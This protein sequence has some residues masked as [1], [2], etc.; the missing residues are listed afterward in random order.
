MIRLEKVN[1]YFNRFKKNQIHVINDTSLDF[2]EKGLVALLGPSGC[3][4]TTLR[5]AIGGRDKINN[6]NIYIN[7]KK[8]PKI[9]H[10]KDKVRTIN[11]GYI[12]QN[13]NL[14]DNLSV[15]DNVA[16]SLKMI[17]IKNKK[18]IDERV[19][20]VLEKV[21]M[22]RFKYRPCNM[23]SGGQRQ[24]V[25]I[26]RAIV[27]NPLLII[28]DEPTGNL[29]SKNTIEIMNIIKSISQS[30]LVILVTHEKD[31]A[32]FY[33][34]RVINIEDGK[35]ISDKENKSDKLD[36]RFD[37]NMYLKDFKYN[38]KIKDNNFNINIYSDTKEKLKLDIVLKNGNIYIKA[39]DDKIEVVDDDSPI[40][41]INDH[42]KAIDKKDYEKSNF[43]LNKLDNSKYR[44]RYASIFNVFSNISNAIKKILGY[45]F[46]KKVLLLGFLASS[47]FILFAISN[48][49]GVTDIQDTSFMTSNRDYIY[50]EA[51]KGNLD[52][53]DKLKKVEG[54]SYILP[55]NSVKSF[56]YVDNSLYQFNTGKV[57]FSASVTSINNI[58]DVIYGKMPSEK[59]EVVVDTMVYEISKKNDNGITF[60]NFNILSA[61]DLVGKKISDGTHSYTISGISN[62][63]SPSIYVDESQ[64]NNILENVGNNKS[65]YKDY[66]NS[67]VTLKEGRWPTGDYETIIN[68][69]NKATTKLNS[70]IDTKINDH[71]LKVVGYYTTPYNNNT[72]Y[73]NSNMIT[74]SNIYNYKGF[75]VYSPN[76]EKTLNY[77]NDNGYKARDTY[78]YDRKKYVDSIKSSIR[79]TCIISGILLGISFIEI[80]LMIRASFMSRIKEVGIMRAIGVKKLDIYKMFMG[81][82]IIIAT[83]TGIPGVIIMGSIIDAISEVPYITNMFMINAKV[84]II[85]LILIYGFN[86]VVGLLPVW[87]TIRKTPASIL[88]RNDV[89]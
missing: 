86:L 8:M 57:E 45:S 30:K 11:I 85:S 42:Y 53:Y 12:F 32:Y 83:I 82:I 88:S 18:D 10:F 50:V 38:E 35:V 52:T 64:F 16:I 2:P 77:L 24:R 66:S 70:E 46:I 62:T 13:Y 15:Y 29:D 87:N 3:G 4:K 59:N 63:G 37:N 28:A 14:L 69:N 22:E 19:N 5:N 78:K 23:L 79:T 39:D 21:G 65:I 41:F 44:I 67:G 73:V 34:D 54:V 17:G 74:I 56:S 36:Y 76:K 51:N 20:Y 68:I 40:E 6:G 61:N 89:D 81:E 27:K 58:K 55:G 49:M 75:T 33:A 43:D 7:G 47:M 80:F 1:K 25:G 71:K 48:I 31:I 72:Y 60:D 9:S 26:A 84:I